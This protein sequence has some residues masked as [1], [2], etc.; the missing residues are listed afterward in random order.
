MLLYG[1][2]PGNHVPSGIGLLESIINNT[3]G[4]N[5][6]EYINGAYYDLSNPVN[7]D[8]IL[9]NLGQSVYSVNLLDEAQN[10]Y[11]NI[12]TDGAT[13]ISETFEW[14]SINNEQQGII[15]TNQTTIA[16]TQ[17][18]INQLLADNPNGCITEI[19]T[20]ENLEIGMSIDIQD[21][22]YEQLVNSVYSETFFTIGE[23]DLLTYL[24]ENVNSGLYIPNYSGIDCT[25]TDCKLVNLSNYD[26]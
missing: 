8:I 1:A 15:D 22:Q 19:E 7:T 6:S 18:L 2:V 10:L 26:K 23:G 13:L 17:V 25:D 5:W 12:C 24:S 21:P 14:I 9:P 20:L 16:E 11:Y 3:S 4:V